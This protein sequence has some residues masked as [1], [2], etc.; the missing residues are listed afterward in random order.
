VT[1][2]DYAI[3]VSQ[4]KYRP[5]LEKLAPGLALLTPAEMKKR[6]PFLAIAKSGTITL[7][8]A[9]AEVPTVV[10]YAISPLDVFLAKYIFKVSLPFYALP[11][12]IAGKMI[13]P[14]LIGPDLTDERLL[15]EVKNLILNQDVWDRCRAQCSS[16]RALLGAENANTKSAQLILSLIKE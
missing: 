6:H 8:L 3:S 5:L 14:E 12:L 15:K 4:E 1:G 7:E 2:Y 13:F 11:N 10:T 9:L 16:L